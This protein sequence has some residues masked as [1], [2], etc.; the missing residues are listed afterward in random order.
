MGRR[1]VKEVYSGTTAN[2]TLDT[3]LKFI[4]NGFKLIQERD[5]LNSDAV[6]RSYTWP[7]L[8]GV[9]GN[10]ETLSPSKITSESKLEIG[11]EIKKQ[12]FCI[13]KSRCF[14]DNL[15]VFVNW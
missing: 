13:K 15:E 1:R 11:R 5:G 7:V 14:F 9:E 4:Y 12:I 2:W 10:G 6:I 3:R 8:S